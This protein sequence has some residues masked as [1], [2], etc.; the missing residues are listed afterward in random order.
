MTVQEHEEQV[1][2][3]LVARHDVTVDCGGNVNL[4]P[5]IADPVPRLPRWV[6]GVANV[7][8]DLLELVHE[9]AADLIALT[10]LLDVDTVLGNMGHGLVVITVLADEVLAVDVAAVRTLGR[11][12]TRES[13]EGAEEAHFVLNEQSSKYVASDSFLDRPWE[14]ELDR[15]AP[16][17]RE[18]DGTVCIRRISSPLG[19]VLSPPLVAH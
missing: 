5:E 12:V 14:I 3:D 18:L 1:E 9:S 11:E 13:I 2:T 17:L 19:V 8:R 4:C 16:H 10:P 6:E 7:R 15:L